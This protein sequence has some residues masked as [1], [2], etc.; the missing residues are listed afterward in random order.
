MANISLTL[1]I[2][3]STY[4]YIPLILRYFFHPT[5]HPFLTLVYLY[6]HYHNPPPYSPFLLT[7]LPVNIFHLFLPIH[8]LYS[9]LIPSNFPFT[10]SHHLN[11]LDILIHN[12]LT[13][14]VNKIQ[15]YPQ[16]HPLMFVMSFV[17]T[18]IYL[19]FLPVDNSKI[20]IFNSKLPSNPWYINVLRTSNHSNHTLSLTHQRLQPFSLYFT[21]YRFR[22]FL[23]YEHP[24]LTNFQYQNP[25]ISTFSE[26]LRTLK[27]G[28]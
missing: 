19:P 8:S 14:Y 21:N 20:N 22:P 25:Y 6:Q 1:P 7:Y 26:H 16:F 10:S 12:L 13:L 17:N 4:F 18:P 28:M 5:P 9:L 2:P 24:I 3:P 11:L 23:I 27:V 15:S